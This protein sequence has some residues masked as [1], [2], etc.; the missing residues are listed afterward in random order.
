M[1][2]FLRMVNEQ[3]DLSSIKWFGG[4]VLLNIG[5]GISFNTVVGLVT[6]MV[7]LSATILNIIK[8]R[9]EI[10]PKADQDKETNE[11]EE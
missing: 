9:K 3:L 8:I 4:T 2:L 11:T 10:K 7:G 1:R 6:L 5:F